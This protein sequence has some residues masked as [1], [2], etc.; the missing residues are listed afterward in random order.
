MNRQ[1]SPTRV[2]ASLSLLLACGYSSCDD[3]FTRPIV[4]GGNLPASRSSSSSSSSSGGSSSSGFPADDDGDGLSNDVELA[5]GLDPRNA[6]SDHDGFADGFEFV[7]R[8]GDPSNAQLTPIS[9]IRS[10]IVEGT[11]LTDTDTDGDGVPDKLERQLGLDPNSPDTDSD[12]YSDGLEL[13][14]GS[15]PKSASSRP[16]REAALSPD[17]ATR[18]GNPP[19]DRDGDGL[20]NDLETQLSTRPDAKDTDSDGY[21]DGVEFIMGSD[22]NDRASIPDFTIQPTPT[23]TILF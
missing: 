4:F 1:L 15:D 16:T 21:P 20:S 7:G 14:A 19:P 12:G 18:T 3:M 23:T 8:A 22:P 5:F 17:G 10:R 2:A 6:D 13:I 9:S 11:A